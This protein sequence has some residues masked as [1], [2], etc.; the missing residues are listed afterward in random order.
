MGISFAQT[1]TQSLFEVSSPEIII[2]KTEFFPGEKIEITIQRMPQIPPNTDP[3]LE[4]Y[5]YLPFLQKIGENVPLNCLG[6]NCIVV[7]LL[8]K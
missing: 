8:M 6:E 3:R 4:L 5:V 7:I 1:E 2:N